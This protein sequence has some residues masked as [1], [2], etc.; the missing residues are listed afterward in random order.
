MSQTDAWVKDLAEE[1]KKKTKAELASTVP[2]PGGS[3]SINPTKVEAEAIFQAL[4][5]GKAPYDVIRAVKRGE[6]TF[7]LEQILDAQQAWQIELAEKSK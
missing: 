3:N 5:A 2:K 4:R 7:S 6:L 1:L